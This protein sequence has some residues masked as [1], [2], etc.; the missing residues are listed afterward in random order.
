MFIMAKKRGLFSH[1]A[2]WTGIFLPLAVVA[3]AWGLF[4]S[5]RE[6]IEEWKHEDPY[7]HVTMSVAG[8]TDMDYERTLDSG[9]TI[10]IDNRGAMFLADVNEDP[11]LTD[12]LFPDFATALSFAGKNNLDLLPSVSLIHWRLK[13]EDDRILE[14]LQ[15]E[16]QKSCLTLLRLLDGEI[17]KG[18]SGDEDLEEAA[19][20]IATARSLDGVPLSS[21]PEQIG[22][23]AR[24]LLDEFESGARSGSRGFNESLVPERYSSDPELAR[25]FRV[26]RFLMGP[27]RP[28][29]VSGMVSVFTGRPDLSMRLEQMNRTLS[30]MDNPPETRHLLDLLKPSKGEPRDR[31]GPI[32]PGI[33]FLPPAHSPENRYYY[34]KYGFA[35][36][37]FGAGWMDDLA[38]GI[39]SGS[40]AFSP[41]DKS[42][43]YDYKLYSLVPLIRRD[44]SLALATRKIRATLEYRNFMEDSFRAALASARE[45]HVMRIEP[46]YFGLLIKPEPVIELSPHFSC[47]PA[48]SVYLRLSRAYRFL[49]KNLP[50]G[51]VSERA[52]DLEETT[53]AL[54]AIS[55]LELGIPPD[56][57]PEGPFPEGF[58]H[59]DLDRAG[60]WLEKLGSDDMLK[61]DPRF[62]LNA[63]SGRKWAIVGVRLRRL[64]YRY[65]KAPTVDGHGIIEKPAVYYAPV[66]VMA[67][68]SRSIPHGDFGE[69]CSRFGS[70]RSCLAALGA[71][72]PRRGAGRIS[73]STILWVFTFLCLLF[74]ASGVW[75]R[76]FRTRKSPERKKTR[77]KILLEISVFILAGFLL[78][79][80]GPTLLFFQIL[81]RVDISRFKVAVMTQSLY[82][83]RRYEPDGGFFR[84]LSFPVEKAAA[85]A[86]RSGSRPVRENALNLWPCAHYFGDLQTE[87]LLEV[88]ETRGY[89]EAD[90]ALLSLQGIRR[91]RDPE[92]ASKL[93]PRV[94]GILERFD[95][96]P[97]MV[98]RCKDLLWFSRYE[99]SAEILE[100]AIKTA[101][102]GETGVSAGIRT[103][104]SLEPE[105]LPY[106][107]V[108]DLGFFPDSPDR[109]TS[110]SL[111]GI[112]VI[113][114]LADRLE[115]IRQICSGGVPWNY[116]EYD[117]LKERWIEREDLLSRE[118]CLRAEQDIRMPEIL[119]RIIRQARDRHTPWV[120][121]RAVSSM[122]PEQKSPFLDRLSSWLISV[123]VDISDPSPYIR[124]IFMLERWNAGD[125]SEDY[126]SAVRRVL[127]S[128]RWND[129]PNPSYKPGEKNSHPRPETMGGVLERELRSRK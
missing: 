39:R 63:A 20:F 118:A 7:S 3:A 66:L 65:D 42:G 98:F 23:K 109:L 33:C 110:G 67:E 84:N 34:K 52:R 47:E 17:G 90:L 40:M 99:K 114:G 9:K 77:R 111:P 126:F 32:P 73:I 46:V 87:A 115:N 57:L 91:V 97:R 92:F 59:K 81:P 44:H 48:P 30:V 86:L 8:S 70:C 41:T 121:F 36:M 56:G 83:K 82:C 101:N 107:R 103:L 96:N 117:P 4:L 50:E 108:A 100:R 120:A 51:I 119:F 106:D 35:L 14:D 94:M 11:S 124:G 116:R 15:L 49:R 64:V 129:Y 89:D 127:D 128:G 80:F 93:L 38:D 72:D 88:A 85:A 112:I 123:P 1:L 71:S 25:M 54:G 69:F 13:K 55:L 6:A 45:T 74:I 58:P 113:S 62:A 68:F 95:D 78:F 2:F 79:R 53:R 27:L 37:P 31:T 16:M 29:A 125:T 61:E 76:Y 10:R 12:R 105:I 60:S 18:L 24:V 28:R 21:R 122:G 5:N 22:K 104:L 26:Q 19:A 43:W 102:P 75:N